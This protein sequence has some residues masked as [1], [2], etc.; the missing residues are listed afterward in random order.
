MTENYCFYF[1]QL[2]IWENPDCSPNVLPTII[3]VQVLKPGSNQV[4]LVFFF[5][6]T[7]KFERDTTPDWLNCIRSE[8]QT[9]CY[10]QMLL[11]IQRKLENKR[12]SVRK[13]FDEYS[14]I[15]QTTKLYTGPNSNHLHTK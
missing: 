3:N 12:K 15:Y 5:Y 10:F 7:Y 8:N 1:S 14:T 6:K 13:F 9:M 2:L 4:H 11:N